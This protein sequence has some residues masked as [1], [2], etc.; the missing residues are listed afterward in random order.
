VSLAA[1]GVVA[2]LCLMA[3]TGCL[4]PRVDYEAE[5]A[6]NRA[7]VIEREEREAHI[8][9]LE[10]RIRLLLQEGRTLQLERESLD[11]ERLELIGAIED[12]R[13][14]N[15][16]LLG[17]LSREREIREGREGEI[18]RISGTYS[19][20]VDELENEV[21]S[22]KLEIHRLEGRLQVRAL[23]RIL[24]D[25]GS[26]QI[27]REGQ[28]VLA[29]VAEQIRKIAGHRIHVEGHTDDVPITGDRFPSNWELSA[30][31]A[32]VVVRFLIENGLD[33]LDLSAVGFGEYH[34]LAPNDT[35]EH[36]ARN[37]RIEIVLVPEQG[38]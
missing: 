29:R 24:F 10:E 22:G 26:T 12:M 1:R 9:K 15:K 25:S 14:G 27:K 28:E 13:I 2:L 3:F 32:A 23:D 4:V 16:E 8:T 33:P 7:L 18:R 20:L 6:R 37:R 38:E 11:L 35:S 21:E 36:R 30:A 17:E 31:R 19:R 5:V 34:P